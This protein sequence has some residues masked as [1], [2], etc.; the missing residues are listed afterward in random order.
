PQWQ[1]WHRTSSWAVRIGSWLNMQPTDYQRNRPL[2]KVTF[3]EA[4]IRSLPP[5]RNH[6]RLRRAV[7]RHARRVLGIHRDRDRQLVPSGAQAVGR[8]VRQNAA[9]AGL[10]LFIERESRVP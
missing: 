8:D 9:L 7:P 10:G 3:G 1:Q 2:T 4:I 6:P 5:E